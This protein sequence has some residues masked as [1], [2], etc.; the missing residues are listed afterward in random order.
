MSLD[1]LASE[2]VRRRKADTLGV[3]TPAPLNEPVS[4][5]E[6]ALSAISKYIPTEVISLFLFGLS[7][8]PSDTKTLG[9]LTPTHLFWILFFFTPVCF[10]LIFVGK[11]RA[12]T[13]G[14][15]WPSKTDFPWWRLVAA[16]A[17]FSIWALA[18]PSNGL[19]D[20]AYVKVFAFAALFASVFFN[21]LEQVFEPKIS[22]KV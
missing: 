16:T 7:V 14:R 20:D 9:W 2:A 10:G 1:T 13:A 4:S 6:N 3:G 11:F 17:G 18:V 21:L 5:P 12:Q 19:V 15:T 22:T 8:L